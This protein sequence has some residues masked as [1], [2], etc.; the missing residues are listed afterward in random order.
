MT[1]G[2]CAICGCDWVGNT[3]GM[4]NLICYECEKKELVDA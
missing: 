4:G 3:D 2:H 1:I